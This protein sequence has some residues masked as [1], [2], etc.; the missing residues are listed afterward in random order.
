MKITAITKLKHGELYSIL[1]RINLTQSE[2]ARRCGFSASEIGLVMNPRKRPCVELANAIQR[3]L[4]ECGEYIDVLEQWPE[5]FHGF[6]KSPRIEQTREVDME[7]F[8]GMH[9]AM[10]IEAPSGISV[11]QMD[12]IDSA[13][14]T[15]TPRERFVVESVTMDGKTLLETSKALGCS[16]ARSSQINAKALR[17][18][19]R[20]GR[21]NI[22][23]GDIPV[24]PKSVQ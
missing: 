23:T 22:L 3:V 20:G 18:L 17:K 11:E 13:L 6:K 9:E 19:R 24:L 8:V 15:L 2:L 16:G 4:G 12:A 7:K 10:M 5:T 1:C 14:S 21:I